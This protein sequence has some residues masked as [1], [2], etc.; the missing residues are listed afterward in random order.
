MAEN[1]LLSREVIVSEGQ[2]PYAFEIRASDLTPDGLAVMKSV[3]D[4]WLNALDRG[5]DPGKV[6]ILARAVEKIRGG[7]DT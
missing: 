4:R 3:Y 6:T 7:D 5:S 1:D 2:R